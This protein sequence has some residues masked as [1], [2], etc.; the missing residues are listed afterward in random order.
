VSDFSKDE[1][2]KYDLKI[3]MSVRNSS[4]T[5]ILERVK[6][7]TIVLEFGPA[8]GA[9]TKYMHEELDCQV[10]IVE[11]DEQFFV[12]AMNYAVDGVCGNASD[13]EWL[14]K[15]KSVKFDYILFAD[16]L[17]HLYDPD[18]VIKHAVSLLKED[19][20]VLLSVPNIAHS[21]IIID[22][23]Q[24][25][26]EYRTEGLLDTTHIRFFTY[27]S[28]MEMIDAAELTAT[29]EDATYA[30]PHQTE[31]GNDYSFVNA[32]TAVL[33]KKNFDS[34]YQ[35]VFEAVK[36]EYFD[37]NREQIV[38]DN[39]IILNST[40]STEAVIY[41]DRGSGFNE[42]EKTV[43]NYNLGHFSITTN[44]PPNTKAV[45]FDPVEYIL[46]AIK[47]L[48][49]YSDTGHGEWENLNGHTVGEYQ[50]FLTKDP[51][52]IVAVKPG[53]TWVRFEGQIT[54]YFEDFFVGFF[55]RTKSL[56]QEMENLV[57]KVAEL[58]ES[59]RKEL[60][61]SEEVLQQSFA[62]FE[63][64]RSQD[65]VVFEEAIQQNREE[66]E[67]ARQQSLA[68]LEKAREQDRVIFEETI[69]QTREEYEEGRKQDRAVFN[70]AI[71]VSEEARQRDLNHKQNE[72][73]HKQNELDHKQCELHI[74]RMQ[75]CDIENAFWWRIT[76]PARI[77]TRG[78]KVVLRY[79]PG[80]K[81][82]YVTLRD[83]HHY[84]IEGTKRLKAENKRKQYEDDRRNYEA[85]LFRRLPEQFSRIV[86]NASFLKKNMKNS[87]DCIVRF[88]FLVVTYNSEKWITNCFKSIF[89]SSF[90]MKNV[91]IYVADNNSSDNTIFELERCHEMYSSECAEFKI[92]KNAKN[93]GFGKGNNI[94]AKA[95]KN[96][97]LFMLNIDTEL[98]DDTLDEIQSAIRSS[99]ENVV[100]WELR[101]FPYEHPKVYSAVTGYTTWCSAAALVVRRSTFEEVGG[102]DEKIFMY[103]EDVDISWRLRAKGYNLKYIPKATVK[104][105]TYV[106]GIEKVKPNQYIFSLINNYNLRLRF[107]EQK[108]AEDFGKYLRALAETTTEFDG[109]REKLLDAY[110]ENEKNVPYFLGW[111][112]ENREDY[113]RHVHKF[114]GYD[115]EITRAGAGYINEYPTMQPLVSVLVRTCGRPDMLREALTSITN[116][117][118]N[119]IEIVVVE[120][121]APTAFEMVASEFKDS[122][123]KYFATEEKV[124]RSAV[125]NIAMKN[126][127]GDY[128]NFLDDDDLFY[129][130]HIEV[131]VR[132][133]E[134]NGMK[135]AFS[136]TVEVPTIFESKAPLV[137][138]ETEYRA[139]PLLA[140]NR[141]TLMQQNLFPIQAVMFSRTFFEKYGGLDET[142]DYNEDWE[143]WFRYALENDFACAEKVTSLYRVPGIPIAE[144]DR[145]RILVRARKIFAKKAS[146]TIRSVLSKKK[147]AVQIHVFYTDLLDEVISNV[148]CIP[149]DYDCY[150]STDT[151]DKKEKIAEAFNKSCTAKNVFIEVFENRGRD[152]M[153]LILQMKDVIKNYDYVCHIHTKKSL[154]HDGVGNPWR[155]YLYKHLFGSEDN[156]EKMLSLLLM[157]TSL[158]MAFPETYD[159]IKPHLEWAGNKKLAEDLLSEMGIYIDLPDD[160]DIAFPSG[161]M[162]WAKTDAIKTLF[163]VDITSK[164]F[165]EEKGQADGTLAHAIERIW[166]YIAEHNGYGYAEISVE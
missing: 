130:D 51:Q 88:D 106:D 131:L 96:E 27:N 28:L 46:C 56:T 8:H 58:E 156:V 144:G 76:K 99:S 63:E 54:A 78:I 97:Y 122:N 139:G 36:K 68:E 55:S 124:G 69:Q 35:F 98:F 71:V 95:G 161:D 47:D 121:G 117:T 89:A 14:D 67:Q 101:Q 31:F 41:Y 86:N 83:W 102:F 16:V 44:I 52:I 15:F 137:Y 2:L 66:Y 123:I 10:Y 23:M 125:G 72:L 13:L 136:R 48:K 160:E 135:A 157:D 77:I 127:Q 110:H 140:F 49:V 112:E 38:V 129:A 91:S 25:K 119:N 1:N 34:V 149:V 50:V 147:I 151:S 107:G 111:K 165:P 33:R 20:R 81:Y 11:Y 18:V 148:N 152:I 166:L 90:D 74:V 60:A 40:L 9:M 159:I 103:A 29:L 153:P 32:D 84:G 142:M 59:K 146:A 53:T 24:N 85:K 26:F 12:D 104:H 114:V 164:D 57:Q 65:R 154:V 126:A 92:I 162:F 155:K 150:I 87:V 105:Y 64:A 70:E 19:G 113:N 100:A 22:L 62:A 5:K 61:A 37:K 118:Y 93:H 39:R 109:A 73:D 82:V 3:D 4:A 80:V 43:I 141:Q 94:A 116:Q 133:V 79:V 108:E 132:A 17:E 128:F 145:S 134:K 138:M 21:A 30:L 143:L 158:G 75:L 45:R 6:P 115:Y 7:S 163:E 42:A 120:D